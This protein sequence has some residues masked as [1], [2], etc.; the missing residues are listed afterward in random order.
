M[1]S[2]RCQ[3]YLV[4]WF[5][6]DLC[7]I[8]GGTSAIGICAFFY[9][10]N[11]FGVVV[12]QRSMLIGRGGVVSLPW[13]YV[14]SSICVKLISCIGF[15]Y[16]YAGLEEE[17]GSV[18]HGYMC[19]LLYVKLIWCS[20]FPEIYAGLEEGV[21]SVCHGYMY[22]LLYVK[23]ICCISFS[24]DLCWIGGGGGVNLSMGICAFLYM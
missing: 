2:S 17:V 12:F 7:S 9:M 23:H 11:L 10:L 14:H 19:I 22:I 15:P 20:S 8:G 6:R 1:H 18:C 16:I 3:T 24:I 5:S 21:E 4:Q 13:V